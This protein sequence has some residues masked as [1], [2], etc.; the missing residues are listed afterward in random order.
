MTAANIGGPSHRRSISR[1]EFHPFDAQVDA[2]ARLIRSAIASAAT[3]E[4]TVITSTGTV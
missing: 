1:S 3:A 4:P 2:I